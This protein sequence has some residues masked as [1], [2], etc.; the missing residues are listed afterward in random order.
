MDIAR[1]EIDSLKAEVEKLK[2]AMGDID[3]EAEISQK[4]LLDEHTKIKLQ[5]AE[6]RCQLLKTQQ[7][8]RRFQNQQHLDEKEQ[9]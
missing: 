4:Y 2:K 8:L 3:H 6:L 9:V 5:K 1:E 7:E